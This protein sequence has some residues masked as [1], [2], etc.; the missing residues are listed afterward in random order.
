M[1]RFVMVSIGFV[2]AACM[3]NGCS[4]ATDDELYTCDPK[5]IRPDP[6]CVNQP[7]V[8]E[9]AGTN[10][11]AESDAANTDA[12]NAIDDPDLDTSSWVAPD[13][14]KTGICVPDPNGTGAISWATVPISL[15]IGPVDQVPAK[16]P[17]ESV[18][19]EKFR[20]F[21]QLVVPPATCSPCSC[22]P[23]E[24]TCNGAPETLELRAGT[25]AQS[26]VMTVP[27][28]A[29]RVMMLRMLRA[30]TLLPFFS[31]QNCDWKEAALRTII[32]EG[33]A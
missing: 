33:R 17:E 29:A 15:W 31:I 18:P 9:D 2:F 4:A 13:A 1:K 20:G 22:G 8:G 30:L 26:G 7:L 23:S 6:A 25:C 10:A 5:A 12:A 24:G 19:T 21:D 32:A 28:D 14:C 27:F 3:I 16:C 11:D